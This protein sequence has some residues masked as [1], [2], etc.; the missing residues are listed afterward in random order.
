MRTDAL[1]QPSVTAVVRRGTVEV[2]QDTAMPDAN[3]SLVH[4]PPQAYLWM[5]L[6]GELR[7][8]NVSVLHLDLAVAL[9]AI[10]EAHQ[11]T[12][13]LDVN[14]S[15]GI[16]PLQ[17]SPLMEL[18]EELMDISAR[19]RHSAIAAALLAIVAVPLHTA[20]LDVNLLMV[21][22]VVLK[23][24]RMALAVA[25]IN[26]YV[27]DLALETVVAQMAIAE[28]LQVIAEPD[29]SSLM[30][31]A[32]PLSPLLLPLKHLCLRIFPWMD[33]AAPQTARS[34]K[35][36]DLETVVV[37]VVIVEVL[38]VTAE[39][40]A[41]SLMEHVRPSLLLL[42]HLKHLCLPIFP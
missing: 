4:V 16:V 25:Q 23:S 41:S 8:T 31:R 24:R 1:V 11:H 18:V 6:V 37:Q 2:Q 9:V 7:H 27:K 28:V 14:H 13:G 20:P 12:V 39:P 21:L 22:V 3:L 15:L 10:V 42:L 30:A 34:A 35:A 17:R 26:I 32:R 5:V 29:V 40:D 19:A 33:L 36:V 38:Q